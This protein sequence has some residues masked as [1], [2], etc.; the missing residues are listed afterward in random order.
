MKPHLIKI[1]GLWHCS[2]TGEMMKTGIGYTPLQA[3]DDWLIRELK[4]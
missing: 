4:S 3:Y 1:N 2:I